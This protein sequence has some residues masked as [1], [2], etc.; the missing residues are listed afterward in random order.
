M[1]WLCFLEQSTAPFSLL[2]KLLENS[3]LPAV[4]GELCQIPSEV[5]AAKYVSL[6]WGMQ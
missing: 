5:H 6:S 2:V 4:N 3:A 1:R